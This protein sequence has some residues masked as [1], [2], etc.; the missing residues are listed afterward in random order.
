MKV[1]LRN[2]PVSVVDDVSD[3][4]TTYEEIKSFEYAHEEPLLGE[5]AG[6]VFNRYL[7]FHKRNTRWGD[8]YEFRFGSS[9]PT[10]ASIY[11]RQIIDRMEDNLSRGRIREVVYEKACEELLYK[12]FEAIDAIHKLDASFFDRIKY[13]FKV[14]S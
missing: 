9:N 11:L 1:P 14:R 13:V 3:R 2:R 7:Q 12:A 5:I 4:S 8:E 6:H 10:K